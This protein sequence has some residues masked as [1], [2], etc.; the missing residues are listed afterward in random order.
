MENQNNGGTSLLKVK[1]ILGLPL[2]VIVEKNEKLIPRILKAV[3]NQMMKR[4]HLSLVGKVQGMR[5][6]I[7][8]VRKWVKWKLPYR[9]IHFCLHF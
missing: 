6:N 7:D 9:S 2:K 5:P 8:D 1:M 4:G 3:A